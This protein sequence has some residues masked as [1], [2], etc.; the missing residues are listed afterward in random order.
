MQRLLGIIGV[1]AAQVTKPRIIRAARPG[2]LRH[3]P[4]PGFHR[5]DIVWVRCVIVPSVV[6]ELVGIHHPAV[7]FPPIFIYEVDHLAPRR[8]VGPVPGQQQRVTE[9]RQAQLSSIAVHDLTGLR[10]DGRESP[11]V[12][13]A[14][15]LAVAGAAD[16]AV[17]SDIRG[18][19][20]AVGPGAL[21]P[22]V[23][24]FQ[25]PFP[26]LVLARQGIRVEGQPRC[27]HVGGMVS[28]H[29]GIVLEMA[30]HFLEV[31]LA[32]GQDEAA[33]LDGITRPVD[34]LGLAQHGAAAPVE[35]AADDPVFR[36]VVPRPGVL[37]HIETSPLPY[38]PLECLR[39]RV[40][41]AEVAE[42]RHALA[43]V[44]PVEHDGEFLVVHPVPAKGYVHRLR[45]GV[46][47][48]MAVLRLVAHVKQVLRSAHHVQDRPAGQVLDGVVGPI[49]AAPAGHAAHVASFIEVTV[50]EVFT[51][52]RL[53]LQGLLLQEGPGWGWHWG[54]YGQGGHGGD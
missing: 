6:P 39:A 51:S 43:I 44:E 45:L 34:G 22:G 26:V 4:V 21:D 16:G 7:L 25:D 2:L 40:T 28:Y 36:V 37:V 23:H 48:D 17:Q 29:V 3:R 47:E 31:A 54:G 24:I 41:Q 27:E 49:V 12:A 53:G 15:P 5:A 9:A 33:L 38:P 35:Q 1:F 30:Q 19:D 18:N 20:P 46:L 13:P 52:P 32:V 10:C 42:D 8:R 50:V 11:P 14:V